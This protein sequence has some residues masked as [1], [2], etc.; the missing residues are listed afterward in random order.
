MRPTTFKTTF[1]DIF[2]GITQDPNFISGNVAQ[3]EIAEYSIE[4]N[5]LEK[6][7]EYCESKSYNYK[8]TQTRENEILL[9]V[10]VKPF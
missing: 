9:S 5:A 10:S 2:Y 7:K 6:F 4:D 8:S 1:E 3:L